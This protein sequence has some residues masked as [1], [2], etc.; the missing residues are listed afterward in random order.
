VCEVF[1]LINSYHGLQFIMFSFFFVARSALR[2]FFY[3]CGIYVW[4]EDKWNI[5]C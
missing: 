4:G 1:V 5:A 3:I 2:C